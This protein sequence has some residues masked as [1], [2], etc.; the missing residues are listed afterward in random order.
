M[1]IVCYATCELVAVFI[2]CLLA[3][4]NISTESNSMSNNLLQTLLSVIGA[5]LFVC[6][7]LWSY[8]KSLRRSLLYSVGLIIGLWPFAAWLV[9]F[10]GSLVGYDSLNSNVAN[11]LDEAGKQYWVPQFGT[12]LLL[13]G[14]ISVSPYFRIR[15]CQ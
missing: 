12:W 9:L 11:L 3:V 15:R 14:L 7:I 8:K 6:C 1:A 13:G 2:Y 4:Y 5:A 10:A